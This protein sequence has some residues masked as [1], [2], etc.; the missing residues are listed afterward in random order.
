MGLLIVGFVLG[1]WVFPVVPAERAEASAV[2]SATHP[3]REATWMDDGHAGGARAT[4]SAMD[5]E[6]RLVRLLFTPEDD[7]VAVAEGLRDL[8]ALSG[9]DTLAAWRSMAQR[10]PRSDYVGSLVA[11][12]LWSR[13][14]AL[15]RDTPVP[16]GWGLE[17][18]PALAAML[19][20]REDAERVR[21][22]LLSGQ[23][24]SMRERRLF[25]MD[26]I[27]KDPVGSFSLW[28]ASYGGDSHLDEIPWFHRMMESDA[29]RAALMAALASSPLAEAEKSELL[30]RLFSAWT[31]RDPKAA[32]AWLNDP[33][34]ASYQERLRIAH[35]DQRVRSDP[36]NAWSLSERLPAD[37]RVSAQISAAAILARDNP[38]LGISRVAE[39]PPGEQRAALV[40]TFGENLALFNYEKWLSWRAT[41]DPS[42]QDSVSQAAFESWVDADPNAALAWMSKLPAGPVKRSVVAEFASRFAREDPGAVVNWIRTLPDSKDRLTAVVAGLRSLPDDD[43]ANQVILLQSLQ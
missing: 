22:A 27:Q 5:W 2:A 40:N 11:A 39:L 16:G 9:A 20:S 17:N 34:V 36:Q 26:S 18:Y 28:I 21:A 7:L 3:A 33:A 8:F 4:V 10:P 35:A 37:Q 15:D 29:Q 12:Y 30:A 24:V 42:E 19:H 25:F 31:A 23:P 38:D 43:H 1:R 13:Q 14:A 6:G 32:E 41:L